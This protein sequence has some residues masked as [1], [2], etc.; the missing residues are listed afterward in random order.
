MLSYTETVF[1]KKRTPFVLFWDYIRI[2]PAGRAFMRHKDII[3][4]F[5]LPTI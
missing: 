5:T 4:S 3:N 2:L 1:A